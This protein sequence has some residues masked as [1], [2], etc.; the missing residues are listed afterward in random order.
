MVKGMAWS[1]AS[2]G[3]LLIGVLGTSCS[4]PAPGADMTAGQIIDNPT[5]YV[6]QSLTVSGKVEDL[7]GPRAF[8]IDSG[9]Q[10]G[11]LLVLGT[12]PFPQLDTLGAAGGR[13]TKDYTA[14]I[15]GTLRLF[16][17]SEVEREVGWDL[18]PKI[19]A[20]F[21]N[22]AVLIGRTVTFSEGGRAQKSTGEP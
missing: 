16:V 6:N 15:T 10:D 5:A 9:V 7:H 1:S 11:D 2:A 13:P 12:E 22:K 17:A 19:E 18:D 20:E 3:A 8:T 21:E 4:P 14:T